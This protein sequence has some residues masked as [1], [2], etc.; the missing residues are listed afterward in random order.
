MFGAPNINYG[1][2]SC[3]DSEITCSGA[4]SQRE[5]SRL[6]AQCTIGSV[7]LQA[8]HGL[9]GIDVADLLHGIQHLEADAARRVAQWLGWQAQE[10]VW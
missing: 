2:P 10:R 3:V 9:R 8:G 6:T 1:A 5:P 4:G 7:D